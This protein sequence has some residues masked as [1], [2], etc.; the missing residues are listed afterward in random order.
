VVKKVFFSF[1]YERDDW[2]ADVVRQH[3]L[4]KPDREAAEYVNAAGWKKIEEHGDDAIKRWIQ[5]NLE[6]TSVTVV[7]IG[8]ETSKRKWVR[9]EIKESRKRGNGILAINICNIKDQN[10]LKCEQ[11]SDQFGEIDKD[12]DGKKLFFWDLYKTY[13]WI[14]DDGYNNFYDWV[15]E[16]AK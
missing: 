14:N 16:V 2:R 11:G 1:D 8:T 4:T 9:Y 13:D 10:E 7:L 5:R 3:W 15:E 12:A 6:G